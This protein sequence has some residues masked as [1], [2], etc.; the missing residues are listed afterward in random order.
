MMMNLQYTVR[1]ASR[2][3]GLNLHAWEILMVF[4]LV[5]VAVATV[6]VVALTRK[7]ASE[8]KREYDTYKLTVDAKVAE[9]KVEGIKAGEAA[10]D[11]LVR[12]AALEKE[13][14][15]LAKDAEEAK[16]ETEHLK[17]Q[18]AWRHLSPDQR[19]MIV[20]D[21]SGKTLAIHFDYSQN[22][23]EAMQFSEDLLKA[24]RDAGIIAYTHPLVAPPPPPGVI[25]FGTEND[26]ACQALKSALERA[27]VQ[28]KLAPRN[29]PARLSIGSKVAPF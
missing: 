27:N 15:R 22:D 25:I 20:D 2:M 3:L 4:S 1:K 26:P 11:A 18:V 6:F 17:A 16:L 12:A 8:I 7:E 29:G 28:F 24:I 19:K 5:A 23:P 9:A 13:A 10:G 14:A 21:L